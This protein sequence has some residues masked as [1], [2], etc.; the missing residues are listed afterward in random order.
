[1]LQYFN[2]VK[3]KTDCFLKKH[4]YLIHHCCL[5]LEARPQT[6]SLQKSL[7]PG[8]KNIFVKQ[9]IDF[10]FLG[11]VEFSLGIIQ[12]A[13]SKKHFLCVCTLSIYLLSHLGAS[14]FVF[15]VSLVPLACMS[16]LHPFHTTFQYCEHPGHSEGFLLTAFTSDTTVF[17][18]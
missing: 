17:P 6:C 15:L 18:L 9:Y 5:D 12:H 2:Y 10:F 3:K 16:F 4:S 1:M 14:G 8:N 13:L 11:R 7:K